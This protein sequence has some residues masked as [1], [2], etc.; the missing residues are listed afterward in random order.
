MRE[1]TAAKT[2][3]YINDPGSGIRVEKVLGSGGSVQWK[4]Y[5]VA[6]G[7]LI[8]EHFTNI[9]GPSV[10]TATRYFVTDHL[11]SVAVITDETGA[12]VERLS[13][14]AW[15]KHRAPSGA[16][17]PTGSITSQTAKGFTGHEMIDEVVRRS[18]R[19]TG[20]FCRPR[21]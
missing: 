3:L 10:T 20:A 15:G 8:G 12:V 17:D 1:V 19:S 14:D 18:K 5:L 9:A 4:E 21:G 16:D 11:G 13:Y 6:G 2:T 7:K